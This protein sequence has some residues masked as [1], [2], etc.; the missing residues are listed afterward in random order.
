VDGKPAQTEGIRWTLKD[1]IVYHAP[2][3]L[4]EVRALVQAAREG[5]VERDD[6]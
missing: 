5:K 2:T 1:G 4:G 6:G 3:L